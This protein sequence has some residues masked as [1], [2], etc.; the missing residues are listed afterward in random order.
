ME[1]LQRA[2]DRV[3]PRR[4]MSRDSTNMLLTGRAPVAYRALPSPSTSSSTRASSSRLLQVSRA[5]RK[6]VRC[7]SRCGPP[8]GA[9]ARRSS[10]PSC[11]LVLAR[12]P[13]VA[14]AGSPISAATSPR[15]SGSPPSPSSGS[16]TGSTPGP[17]RPPRRSTA[18]W[19]RSRPGVALLPAGSAART[20]RPRAGAE[21][22]CRARGGARATVRCRWSSTAAR[23]DE[24]G[25]ARRGRGRRRRGRR[26]ARL[27]PRAA[28][29]GARRRVPRCTHRRGA[30]RRARSVA[31]P[32]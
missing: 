16:P 2:R 10:P 26:R 24:P 18:C 19:S 20:L 12:G 29:R 13:L 23:A 4:A 21:S 22:R 17:R 6:D 5:R 30:R 14:G 25:G 7:S 32:A 28:A 1:E 27:L 15:S 9:P 11:A 8:R 31:R 3:R